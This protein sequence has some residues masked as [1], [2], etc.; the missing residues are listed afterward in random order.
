MMTLLHGP[1]C[2]N[3]RH[4]KKSNKF[5]NGKGAPDVKVIFAVKKMWQEERKSSGAVKQ[6]FNREVKNDDYGVSRVL[7]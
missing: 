3:K 2:I 4:M 7:E 5:G 6:H 1:T